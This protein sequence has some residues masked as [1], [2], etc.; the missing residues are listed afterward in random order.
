LGI[1]CA[2]V[3]GGCR[4]AG[5]DVGVV[6]LAIAAGPSDAACLQVTV[7]GPSGSATRT[8]GLTPGTPTTGTLG[9][10]P[11][12]AVTVEG[13]AFSSRCAALTSSS[14][15]TWLADPVSVVLTSGTAVPVQLVMHPSGQISISVDWSTGTDGGQDAAGGR[16]GAGGGQG[17]AGGGQAGADGGGAD[18]GNRAV[19]DVLNGQ[20]WL[21]PCRVDTQAA[22]CSTV[23]GSC[24]SSGTD[25]VI[26]GALLTDKTVTLGGTVGTPYTITVHVQGEVESKTYTGTTDQDNTALTPKADGFATG[27]TPTSSDAYAVYLLRVTN[28][29]ATTHTDYFLNSLNPPG[30]SNHTTYGVDYTARISA[31]GGATVRL[32]EADGN[33]S[34]IKNCG[35]MTNDGSICAAP[36][37]LGPVIE[38]QARALNPSFNF[39]QAY[40]GQWLVMVVKDVTSP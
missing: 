32:V 34:Q 3:L 2:I 21:A 27:G 6:K 20:M 1:F 23:T 40:N 22:V 36:I 29:G 19:A 18:G 16:A 14:I 39:D 38:P 25:P 24:P 17:G 10:L 4:S 15:P 30:V 26:K 7:T 9:G 12:G 5:E 11:L 8:L 13:Q 31:Q 28:P 33:C 37:I 35:P